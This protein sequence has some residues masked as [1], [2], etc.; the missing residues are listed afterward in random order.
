MLRYLAIG[1]GLAA[2]VGLGQGLFEQLNFRNAERAGFTFNGASVFYGYANSKYAQI[3]SDNQPPPN[4]NYGANFSVGWQHHRMKTNSSLLYSGS[5]GGLVNYPQ[6]NRYSQ[7]LSAEVSSQLSGKWTGS[8]A[9]AG[10]DYTLSESLFQGTSLSVTSQMVTAFNDF[11]A[12]LGLGHFSTNQVQSLFDNLYLESAIRSGLLGGRVL[13]YG[14]QASLTYAYT[15]N[16]SV[17]FTG[18]GSGGQR[19]GDTVGTVTL[20]NYAMSRSLGGG[21]GMSYL[22]PV[23]PRTEVS[24]NLEEQYIHNKYQEALVT[25]GTVSFGR[26]MGERW[27]L[28]VYGG[29]STSDYLQQSIG[30]A[31]TTQAVGGGSLGFQM[32]THTLTATYDRSA[33]NSYGFSVG[34][35]TNLNASWSW[36]KVGSPV[37]VF[38]GF[39]QQQQRST[40]FLSISGWDASGGVSVNLGSQ[41]S[42]SLTYAYLDTSARYPANQYNIT[43]HSIRASLSLA[44]HP[45]LR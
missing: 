2:P 10:Q 5:Y 17:H 45:A 26:K 21:G 30:Q 39:S 34:T 29:G 22:I 12:H 35:N 19:L 36:H 3:I 37:T 15:P 25:T 9:V 1:A 11:A 6:F 44:P 20:P 16:L 28:R 43:T 33:T 13:S 14:G 8:L 7:S 18:F 40:G 27:F 23:S 32:V 41:V 31:K 38:T 4:I 42:T 24:V